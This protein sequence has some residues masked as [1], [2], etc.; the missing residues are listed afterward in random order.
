MKLIPSDRISAYGAAL[1]MIVAISGC[2]TLGG[3]SVPAAPGDTPFV[4][5]KT[6]NRSSFVNVDFIIQTETTT[7]AGT[8]VGGGT[9]TDVRAAGGDEA[10]VVPC[11]VDRIGLGNLDDPSS[12]GLRIS[13]PGSADKTDLAWGQAPLVSGFSYNCGD[14]VVFLLVDD[15]NSAGGVLVT[16]GLIGGATEMGPFG[17]PDTFANLEAVLRAEGLLP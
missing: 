9:L 1:A 17:G 10:L 5:I 7:A 16:T 3:S 4:M 11:P 12:T 13:F 6:I 14:T 15:Q 2:G 8:T